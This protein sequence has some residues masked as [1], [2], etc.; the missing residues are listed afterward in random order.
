MPQ[1]QLL[2]QLAHLQEVLGTVVKPEDASHPSVGIAV[3]LSRDLWH[4]VS[5]SLC[6]D[7]LMGAPTWQR[8]FRVRVKGG[9][10]R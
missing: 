8:Q 3:G 7:P 6:A 2:F 1:V 5:L 10:G 4:H 9:R